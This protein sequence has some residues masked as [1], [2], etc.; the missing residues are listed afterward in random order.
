MT[1]P[2]SFDKTNQIMAKTLQKSTIIGNPCFEQQYKTPEQNIR[3]M[4]PAIY[5]NDNK[6]IVSK[7]V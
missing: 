2:N 1:L 4:N 6:Y 3:K 7:W 5:K